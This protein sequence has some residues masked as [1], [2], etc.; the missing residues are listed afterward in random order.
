MQQLWL[1]TSGAARGRRWTG[2]G[3]VEPAAPTDLVGAPVPAT[4]QPVVPAPR[5]GVVAPI[6]GEPARPAMPIP[7]WVQGDPAR[8]SKSKN[9]A[10][11]QRNAQFVAR[12]NAAGT[13][14]DFVLYGDSIT[15]NMVDKS[16][17]VWS[18]YFGGLR[19][20]PL[21]VGGNTVEELSWRVSR[22]KEVFRVPPRA[23][24]VLI[25]YNNLK[26]GAGREPARRLDE[27]LLP[28]L[29]QVY[30]GAKVLL[31][32]LLPAK[33]HNTAVTNAAYRALAAK[34]GVTFVECGADIN[35]NDTRDLED[36]THP[37]PG[38]YHK[39]FK[40][41]RPAVDAALRGP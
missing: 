6:S 11:G 31:L 3:A 40:C 32:A 14:M 24:G 34:H 10:A 7:A 39:L 37:A 20:A 5:G 25:G 2:G 36:G 13:R 12:A 29:K 18:Q 21:G 41:L 4:A 1:P 30:P 22:G 23:V 35:P 38:G 26:F 28:W 9:R 17:T 33:E 8:E 27:F 15:R 19:A 16:P